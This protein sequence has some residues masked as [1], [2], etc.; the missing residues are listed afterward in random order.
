M[1]ARNYAGQRAVLAAIALSLAASSALAQPVRRPPRPNTPYLTVQV[2]RSA[3]RIAGPEASDALRERLIQVY[4]GPVLWV[5]DKPVIEEL[6]T[7]S[8]YETNQQLPRM[9]ENLLAKQVRA[10]E[11]IRGS[12]VREAD[13]QYRID[14]QL[15]LTRDPALVQ[16]LPPSRGRN[17][18]RAALGLV[19]PIQQAR[20]QL[21]NEKEC[22]EHARA[23]RHAQA[24]EAANEAIEDYPQATLV[25]YC[26]MNVL[27]ASKA[28]M[29]EVLAVANEILALD[30]NNRS[31]LAVAAD[32]QRELGNVDEA[33]DLLVRLLSVDPT[34]STLATQVVDAL[35][36]S[37]RWDVAKQI[38]LKAVQDN[39]GDVELVRLQFLI[40]SSAGDY[41]PAIATGEQMIQ[42]DTALANEPFW[43]RLTALYLAD[44]QP[45]MAAD[46]A[47]R[48]TMK[49]PRN[50]DLWQLR[51]QTLRNSATAVR[52]RGTIRNG[53]SATVNPAHRDSANAFTLQAIE[54]S[55][56]ALA[57]DPTITNGWLQVAQA[58]TELQMGDSV[59]VALRNA[60]TA[61]DNADF[62][63]SLA[64]GLGNQKRLAGAAAS[65]HETL[66]EAINILQWADTIT[67][68]NDS[69]GPPENR[70]LRTPASPETRS[71]VKFILGVTA[72][73]YAQQVA[74]AAGAARDCELSRKADEAL[75]TAQIALPAG[76]STNQA[77]VVQLLQAVPELSNF[78]QQQITTF[79][80]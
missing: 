46:A 56:Q 64:S 49:F 20:R 28:P 72:V 79:C 40:L 78:V 25:R 3:D 67:M 26:K 48:A 47:R 33:N 35:A 27:I 38:V 29:P 2:F 12:V 44:S 5:I 73:T 69:V 7:Q 23:N 31:A 76:A 15:V 8:G 65:S 52:L 53:D 68:L 21:D 10:D 63:A 13:G 24:L 41:K 62:I 19:R 4:P 58:Y 32:A 14:A 61:G 43:T 6:L 74:T 1:T 70:R 51:A 36:A 18:V 57:I 75:I 11:Y 17:A 60:K 50:A 42:L 59:L 34:N 45:A 54:A 37:R 16:P 55:K 80:K 30:E 22:I 66:A 71:R 77:A 39:P 9:D